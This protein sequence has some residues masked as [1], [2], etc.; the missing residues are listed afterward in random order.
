MEGITTDQ[1]GGDP[2]QRGGVPTTQIGGV[3]STQIGGVPTAQLGVAGVEGV[4]SGNLASNSQVSVHSS[5]SQHP[6]VQSDHV[7][8]GIEILLC[9]CASGSFELAL[10]V[11]VGL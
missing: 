9:V 5:L 10:Q 1:T 8:E 2:I 11:M 7:T 3:P 4:D 6:P